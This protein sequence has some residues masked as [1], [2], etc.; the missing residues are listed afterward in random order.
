MKL[1]IINALNPFFEIIDRILDKI[2]SPIYYWLLIIIY[3][4]YLATFF[5]VLYVDKSYIHNLSVFM[6]IFIATILIIR[7]NPF[8]KHNLRES[9][10]TL[11][12][13]SALFLLI[14]VGLTE[15][16]SNYVHK[17]LNDNIKPNINNIFI[18]S[19][20]VSTPAHI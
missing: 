18:N 16:F 19:V 10:N 3:L 7:F 5:G 2:T 4:I 20:P 17:V 12:F 11:I 15:S 6:Q 13:S 9:D 14:N 1:Y 8:R